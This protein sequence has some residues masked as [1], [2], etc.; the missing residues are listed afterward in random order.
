MTHQCICDDCS[1]QPYKNTCD[2]EAVYRA[3]IK[4][5]G[6]EIGHPNVWGEVSR[7]W[8]GRPREYCQCKSMEEHEREL[9]NSGRRLG[10]AIRAERAA[11]DTLEGPKDE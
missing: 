8:D 2:Y 9:R 3:T 7:W 10:E 4:R 1:P 5:L 6:A 11:I